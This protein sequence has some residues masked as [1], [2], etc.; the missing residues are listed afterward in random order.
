MK[1]ISYGLLVAAFVV[2]VSSLAL[3]GEKEEEH[4]VISGWVTDTHCGAKGA[5]EGHGDCAA[6]CVK[7][8]GAKWALYDPETKTMWVLSD[9]E[10]GA[11][12]VGKRVICRG[13]VDKK[14]K[15]IKVSDYNLS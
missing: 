8:K 12:M 7:E 1:K 15:E 10:K 9:Q 14:K 13:T 5:V 11:Q 2:G 3:A 6:R 4:V